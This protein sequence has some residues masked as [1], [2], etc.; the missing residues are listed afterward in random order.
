MG[1]SLNK[2][3]ISQLRRADSIVFRFDTAEHG[4]SRIE[5]AVRADGT[6]ATERTF[7]LPVNPTS[8]EN[9][10]DRPI[11]VGCWIIGQAKFTPEWA[12]VVNMLRTGDE[13]YPHYVADSHH[14]SDRDDRQPTPTDH[15][16]VDTFD[17][18][19]QRPTSTGRYKM[20]TFGLGFQL[21]ARSP[22][23]ISSR[24]RNLRTVGY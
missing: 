13:L 14:P 7:E 24:L 23:H 2:D 21:T 10:G 6:Y 4:F 18:R 1:I 11:V 5:G 15:L 20:L 19:V 9:Y 3:D 17:L 22:E 16:I 8:V 12:T